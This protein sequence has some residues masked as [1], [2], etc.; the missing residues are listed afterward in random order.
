MKNKLGVGTSRR[1]RGD[2]VLGRADLRA[3]ATPKNT[4]T[5]A[6]TPN[7]GAIDHV[8]PLGR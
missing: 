4:P 7:V 5:A 1:N 2:L 8:D 6:D 3:S